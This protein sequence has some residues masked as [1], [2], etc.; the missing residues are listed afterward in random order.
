MF[1]GSQF[2]YWASI[3]VAL[4]WV[5]LVMLV[6]KS[7]LLRPLTRPFA[8]VG[9]MAFSNYIMHTVICTTIF[10]GHGFGLYGYAER[11]QQV[12]VVVAIWGVQLA[13]SPLWLKYFRFGP[14]EW[15][16]RSLSYW[17]LQPFLRGR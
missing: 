5:G 11:W 12:C 7:D 14:L 15:L 9:R 13:I 6:C 10:Y 16:W 8:A 1:L 3:L 2:N 17:R 4:G